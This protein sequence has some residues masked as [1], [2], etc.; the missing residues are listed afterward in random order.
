MSEGK[1]VEIT[2]RQM[3]MVRGLGRLLLNFKSSITGF[4]GPCTPF[5]S[6]NPFI[7]AV[8]KIA[9]VPSNRPW[10]WT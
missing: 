6:G 7:F 2:A 3:E 9:E 8:R 4:L 1:G 10:S 5:V